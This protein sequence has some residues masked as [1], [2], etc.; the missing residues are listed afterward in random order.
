MV[1]HDFTF[2]PAAEHDFSVHPARCL[3]CL[4][5]RSA[6]A[7]SIDVQAIEAAPP[8]SVPLPKVAQSG[9]KAKPA[10]PPPTA[11]QSGAAHHQAA[12][13]QR[14]IDASWDAV[15]TELNI[16]NQSTPAGTAFT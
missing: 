9:D 11:A 13:R 16:R 10:S 2:S 4:W 5:R 1:A 6:E 14:A 8:L 15:I 12:E 3:A 7:T